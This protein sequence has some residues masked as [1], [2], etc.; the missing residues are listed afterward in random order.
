MSFLF[1]LLIVVITCVL[2]AIF[3]GFKRLSGGKPTLRVRQPGQSVSD[4]LLG[5]AMTARTVTNGLTMLEIKAERS[6][7]ALN[8]WSLD[9]PPPLAADGL[10]HL[11][12]GSR[13]SRWLFPDIIITPD[14]VEIRALPSE[15]WDVFLDFEKYGEWN[16]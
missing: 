4:Y 10:S 5:S 11:W 16:G 9:V 7:S 8:E 1:T 13:A 6:P 12:L 2:A 14:P 3:D 15:V